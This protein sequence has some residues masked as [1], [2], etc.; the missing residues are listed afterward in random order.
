MPSSAAAVAVATPCWPAPGLGHQSGLAHALREERLAE[1]VVDLVRAGV[2]Q[3]FAL[4]QQAQAELLGQAVAFGERRRPA[5]VVAQQAVE[6]GAELGVAPRRAERALQLAARGDER[7]GHEPSTEPAEAAFGGGLPHDGR[8]QYSSSCQSNG[9][10][11]SSPLV[12]A[13]GRGLG[14]AHEVAHLARVLATG[15]VLDAGRHVDAPRLH[16]FD[17]LGHVLGRQPSGQ[18]HAPVDRAPSASDQSNISPEPGACESMRIASAPKSSGAIERGIA[19]REPLDHERHL[20]AHQLR[21]LDG[22]VTVQLRARRPMLL[23]M[24]TTR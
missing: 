7:L 4:E 15:A 14:V 6:L 21:L 18:D 10:S 1:D 19:C 16:A 9:R 22:L 17:R 11:S 12:A 24:S 20:R 8:G 5:G 2:V 23:T 3:V 13:R